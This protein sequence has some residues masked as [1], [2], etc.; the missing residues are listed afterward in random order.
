MEI[1]MENGPKLGRGKNGKKMDK[2]WILREFSII[3][4]FLGPFFCHF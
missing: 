2:K 4:Q 3:F 1:K